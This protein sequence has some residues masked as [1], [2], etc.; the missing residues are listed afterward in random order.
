MIS[1]FL[2]TTSSLPKSISQ[3][4]WWC[5]PIIPA[6]GRWRQEFKDS[7]SYIVSSGPVWT[8]RSN[9]KTT[10]TKTLSGQMYSL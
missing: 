3:K 8:I 1:M 9:F 4:A 7:L 6:L 10:T 5:T 2:S